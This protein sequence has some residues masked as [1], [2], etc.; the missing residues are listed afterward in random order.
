MFERIV[1]HAVDLIHLLVVRF[2]QLRSDKQQNWTGVSDDLFR[3]IISLSI[4]NI[5]SGN[6][7]LIALLDQFRLRIHKC[8]ATIVCRIVF[9]R[10]LFLHAVFFIHERVLVFILRSP[11][12]HFHQLRYI[13]T[14]LIRTEIDYRQMIVIIISE[15]DTEQVSIQS[16]KPICPESKTLEQTLIVN[17]RNNSGKRKYDILKE[18][19]PI[20]DHQRIPKTTAI[21]YGI[22]KGQ[23]Q[24]QRRHKRHKYQDKKRDIPPVHS[25]QHTDTERKLDCRKVERQ[26]YRKRL[27]HIQSEGSQ[28]FTDLDRPAHRIDRLDKTGEDKYNSDQQAAQFCQYL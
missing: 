8:P 15:T 7:R 3:H 21:R 22:E 25:Q 17:K 5:E 12:G 24:S 13:R 23:I 10:K 19:L 27:Q 6:R 4:V 18:R 2:F 28:V 9:K 20:G 11:F 16:D 14:D 26:Q 1:I